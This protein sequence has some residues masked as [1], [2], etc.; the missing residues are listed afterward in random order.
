[1]DGLEILLR[2]PIQASSCF[3]TKTIKTGLLFSFF[4]YHLFL[5]QTQS[6]LILLFHHH[7]LDKNDDDRE[8]KRGHT[9][10]G[11]KRTT[12]NNLVDEKIPSWRR[13]R[14]KK[15]TRYKKRGIRS[16]LYLLF[17]SSISWRTGFKDT[18]TTMMLHSMPSKRVKRTHA[19]KSLCDKKNSII[20]L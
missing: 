4:C 3:T 7:V 13:R 15:V 20:S 8:K 9:T 5:L 11:M 12:L 1:M 10:E 16:T 18:H 17:F 2:F 6:I 19:S 14:K